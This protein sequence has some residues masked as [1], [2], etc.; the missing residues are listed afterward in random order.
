MDTRMS[1]VNLWAHRA[2]TAFYLLLL[3][4]CCAMAMPK[5]EQLVAVQV[6]SLRLKCNDNATTCMILNVSN[7][8]P[9]TLYFPTNGAEKDAYLAEEYYVYQEI[10]PE[11]PGDWSDILLAIG[12]YT[13]PNHFISVPSN[14]SRKVMVYFPG[15]LSGPSRSTEF[16]VAISDRMKNKYFSNTFDANG[17]KLK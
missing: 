2:T 10:T 11:H 1:F 5:S 14:S 4:S 7:R 12:E 13:T 3:L 9:T 16:R 17:N 8:S 15:D 6:V